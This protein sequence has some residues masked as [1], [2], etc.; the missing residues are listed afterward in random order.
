MKSRA[1]DDLYVTL[2]YDVET[3]DGV[4]RVER[5]FDCP[6]DGGHVKEYYD[7]KWNPAYRRLGRSGT[8]LLC[9]GRS[10][11]LSVIRGE[12]SEMRKGAR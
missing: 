2:A 12:Y 7:G 3:Q 10:R 9:G 4:K 8:T 11:L 5:V 1:T 6:A